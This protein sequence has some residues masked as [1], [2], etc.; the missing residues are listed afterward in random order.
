MTAD[1][2]SKQGRF[3]KAYGFIQSEE[4]YKQQEK[5]DGFRQ[6]SRKHSAEENDEG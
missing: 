5:A 2:G 1:N 3:T 4:E 6:E